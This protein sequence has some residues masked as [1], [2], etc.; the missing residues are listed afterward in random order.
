VIDTDTIGVSL[1]MFGCP[2]RCRHCWLGDEIVANRRM[3]EDDLRWVVDKFRRFRRPG[4]RQP[5]WR[6]VNVNTWFREPDYSNE[7]R[8]LYELER[9]LSDSHPPRAKYELLSVWRLARDPAYAEW[10]YSIGVRVAQISFFGM[11]EVTD[12]AFRRRG[13]F[14]DL[15]AATQS[16]LAGGIRPRWQVFFTKRLLSDLPALISLAEELRL[17]KRCE[18]LAGPFVFW[19]HL[20]SPDGQAFDIEHLRPVERDLERV[21]RKFLEQS[22][23]RIGGPMGAPERRLVRELADDDGPAVSA[24]ETIASAGLWLSVTSDFDV[25]ANYAEISALYRLGSLKSDGLA[26]C[27]EVLENDASPGLHGMF[28]V[29]TSELAQRFGRRYG[30]RL[31]GQSDLKLKWARMWAVAHAQEG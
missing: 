4:E 3:T 17:R 8:R 13:A 24:A 11:E 12:W 30:T 2:N 28:R 16:L 31:Y 14:R 10:A 22:E 29:P 27:V 20:P 19:M 9:E 18:D 15:L 5:Y 6:Q 21:P 26:H 1:D 7:Y 25:Y 23:E